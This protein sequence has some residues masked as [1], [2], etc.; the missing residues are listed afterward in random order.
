MIGSGK[1][2]LTRDQVAASFVT[3]QHRIS[4]LRPEYS[5]QVIT[6]QAT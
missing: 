1:Q 2:A 6:M 5:I 3:G 4:A